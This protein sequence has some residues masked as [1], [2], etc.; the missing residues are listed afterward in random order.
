MN[1]FS[2]AEL[3]LWQNGAVATLGHVAVGMAL[4][5]RY[6]RPYPIFS[7]LAGSMLVF[8]TLSLLP[9]LDLIGYKLGITDG[10]PLSHRGALH[11]L[12]AALLTALA[13]ALIARISG[14]EFKRTFNF[15][16]LSMASHGLLDAI[17]TGGKGVAFFWPWNND[18][19]FLPWRPIPV[20]PIFLGLFTWH[21]AEIL[22]LELLWF[23][24]LFLYALWPRSRLW[25]N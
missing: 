24:P 8:T 9:D 7:A 2:V 15:A 6:C 23:S 13:T 20:A 5:R 11:S 25:K 14:I 12:F 1:H 18:R 16:F 4:G 17:T 10:S 21:G 19:F 22:T 3:P